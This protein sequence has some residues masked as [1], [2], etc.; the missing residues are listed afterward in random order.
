[1]KISNR[2]IIIFSGA[3]AIIICVGAFYIFFSNPQ[4]QM[5]VDSMTPA[6]ETKGGAPEISFD[7]V[8]ALPLPE[9]RDVSNNANS[10]QVQSDLEVDSIEH[11]AAVQAAT[12]NI[13]NL[14]DERADVHQVANAIRELKIVAGSQGV[15]GVNLDAAIEGIDLAQA[16]QRKGA[17]LDA[18]MKKMR[19]DPQSVPKEEL[20]KLV[21]EITQM[22]EKLLKVKVLQ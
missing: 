3:V 22:Q 2:T 7:S 5:I 18:L 12:Q 9:V 16:M 4:K 1:M 21:V 14:I 17:E 20:D 6:S 11:A 15:P 13:K 8:P 10:T 19:T